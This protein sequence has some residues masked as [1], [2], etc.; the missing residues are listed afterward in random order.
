MK[1]QVVPVVLSFGGAFLVACSAS[2][3]V[4]LDLDLVFDGTNSPPAN[5]STPWVTATFEDYG[6]NRVCL[7]LNATGNLAGG[8]NVRQFYFNFDDSLDLDALGF[9]Y[10]GS[11]GSFDLP[12]WTFSENNLRAD[13]DGNYDVRLDFATGSVSSQVFDRNESFSCLLTY[14]GNGDMTEHSFNFFSEPAGGSGPFVAAAHVQNTT[15]GGSAWIAADD[16]TLLPAPEPTAA[17][18]ICVFGLALLGRRRGFQR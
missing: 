16:T 10:L 14:S 9:V 13:G 8:E 7:T 2:A 12:G 1:F 5:A 18:L 15:G 6:A 3:Q 17:A 4:R 11:S